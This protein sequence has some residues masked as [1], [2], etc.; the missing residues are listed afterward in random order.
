MPL[1][2]GKGGEGQEL[3]SDE[4]GKYLDDGIPNKSEYVNNSTN[5]LGQELSN[6]QK[7]FFKDSK[8]RDENGNLIIMYHGTPNGTFDVFKPY[9]YFTK[10]KE[11]ADNYQNPFASSTSNKSKLKNDSPKTY[12]VYLNIKKPFDLSDPVAKDIYINEYIKGGW[13]A[14]IDPYM[15]DAWYKENIKNIDWTEGDNLIDFFEENGYDYDGM[16][17]YEG[18]VPKADKFGR[19]IPG[20]YVDRGNSIVPF[21]SNQI[22]SIDNINPTE[23]DSISDRQEDEETQVMKKYFN[24]GD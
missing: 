11:Y 10:D 23:S 19:I 8:I 20:E 5:N 22:K 14:G 1:K 4:T 21:K 15:P 17:L 2:L 6:E 24:L 12:A 3:Y 9:S 7:E 16:V 18:G 13:A